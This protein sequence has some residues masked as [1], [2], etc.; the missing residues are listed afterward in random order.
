MPAGIKVETPTQTEIV[1]KGAD[2]QTGGAD[3]RRNPRVSSARAVQG[4]GRAV[5]RRAW[6]SRKRR[7]SRQAAANPSQR[8]RMNKNDVS[9]P[10][11]RKPRACAS[12][13]QRR[14]GWSWRSD[15]SAHLR[16]DL[17]PTGGTVLVSASTLEPDVRKVASRAGRQSPR[18]RRRSASASRRRRQSAGIDTVAFDRSG[19]RYHGRVKALADAAREAGLK[20]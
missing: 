2:K 15:Q 17:A 12:P 19:F 4:Q 16:S 20:F 11:R 7:R 18:P 10:P 8:D 3:R 5:R 13:S 1:I 6:S 14:T 9:P